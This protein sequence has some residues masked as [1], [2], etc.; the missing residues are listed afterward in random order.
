MNY[1]RS[2]TSSDVE[3]MTN[4]AQSPRS[5]RGL[6]HSPKQGGGGPPLENKE[7]ILIADDG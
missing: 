7:R 2:R 3:H 5:G 1:V 4:L 6:L